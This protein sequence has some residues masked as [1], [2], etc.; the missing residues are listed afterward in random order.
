MGQ[1]DLRSASRETI[2]SV[3]HSE[4]QSGEQGASRFPCSAFDGG[5]EIQQQLDER[6]LNGGFRRMTAGHQHAHRRARRAIHV[7]QSVGLG[8]GLEEFAGDLNGVGRRLLPMSFDAIGRHVV[9]QG[10]TVHGRV[11]AADAVRSGVDKRAVATKR[12]LERCEV[13]IHHGLDRG[14]EFKD[15]VIREVALT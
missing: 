13:A 5:A 1:F 12:I 7:G 11:E 8:A 4:R 2:G 6:H 10:G 9:E 14:L 15:G 3:D